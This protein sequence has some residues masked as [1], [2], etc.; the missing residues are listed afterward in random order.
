MTDA[1]PRVEVAR[2]NTTREFLLFA[3]TRA[4]FALISYGCYLLVL[5]WFRYEVAY[6][7]SYVVGIAIAYYGSA[8]L[9]FKEP[10]RARSA[11]LFPLVYVVQFLVGFVLI[12][13]AVETLHIPEWLALG[14][15][16]LITLPLTFVLSRWAVRS[17]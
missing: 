12:W 3:F 4:V 15:S 9:V 7:A 1:A 13:L 11:L 10:M 8:V 2:A 14:F 5:L 6:V 16:V 17:A